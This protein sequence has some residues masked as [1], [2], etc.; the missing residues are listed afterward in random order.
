M[1]AI[2]IVMGAWLPDAMPVD[3][4]HLSRV[5]MFTRLGSQ[6]KPSLQAIARSNMTI[7]G[8]NWLSSFVFYQF[9]HI[10]F[11]V[12]DILLTDSMRRLGSNW[13]LHIISILKYLS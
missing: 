12:L 5:T 4:S 10:G 6:T 11:D 2:F 1:P 13:L 8:N 7:G 3:Y 9:L